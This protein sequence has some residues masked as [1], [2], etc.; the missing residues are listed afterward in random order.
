M[1]LVNIATYMPE[2]RDS[3]RESQNIFAAELGMLQW[4]TRGYGVE[5][6]SDEARCNSYY[7]EALRRMV[8]NELVPHLRNPSHYHILYAKH[9]I[10]NLRKYRYV[11]G[12]ERGVILRSEVQPISNNNINRSRRSRGRHKSRTVVQGNQQLLSA[13]TSAVEHS[14]VTAVYNSMPLVLVKDVWDY[15]T[16]TSVDGTADILIQCAH[17]PC[18]RYIPVAHDKPWCA[19]CERIEV[20]AP[21]MVHDADF[22]SC[23]DQC[24]S[25]FR[26]EDGHRIQ[27]Q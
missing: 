7:N 23:E 26:I 1:P 27:N 5:N 2:A 24:T 22:N 13:T 8:D 9:L 20:H 18:Q 21:F 11:P 3:V 12:D 19:P 10:L 17:G 14:L 15:N 4:I 16:N 6:V 25:C